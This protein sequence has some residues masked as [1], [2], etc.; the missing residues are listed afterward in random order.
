MGLERAAAMAD[1]D[2]FMTPCMQPSRAG[3]YG[4]AAMI[5]PRD[6]ALPATTP[7]MDDDPSPR[8][9][10]AAAP[11]RRPS[12]SVFRQQQDPPCWNC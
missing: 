9:R 7:P 2:G 6:G 8:S 11:G 3:P 12:P 1:Y 10:P 4:P 5:P